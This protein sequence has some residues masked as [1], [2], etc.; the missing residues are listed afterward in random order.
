MISIEQFQ[1]GHFE[2]GIGYQYFVPNKI[3][4]EWIWT[5]P[6]INQLLEKAAIKL[7]ELNS[8]SRLVPNID[9]FIKL[10]VTKEAVVSSRIEGT[11]TQMDEALLPEEEIRPER[12][13]DWKEVNNYINAI[14]NAILNLD[15]LPISSRLI[16]ATHKVLLD[17]VEENT[18]YL[19]LIA[20]VK[21]GLEEIH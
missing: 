20:Q 10:H 1:A 17:S 14:D 8:Y 15:K 19:A 16:K 3:N 4:D 13:N 21:I 6:I 9:L 18:N 7:G 11:Q 12:R 5:S 2:Q